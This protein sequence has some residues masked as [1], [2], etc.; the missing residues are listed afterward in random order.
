M[1]SGVETGNNN[2][3]CKMLPAKIAYAAVSVAGILLSAFINATF[4]LNYYR[5]EQK[6]VPGVKK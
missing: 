1:L 3:G 2:F 4:Y 6:K 5:D